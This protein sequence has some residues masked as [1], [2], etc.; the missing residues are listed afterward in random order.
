[1]LCCL[2]RVNHGGVCI[3]LWCTMQFCRSDD[4]YIY[5]FIYMGCIWAQEA[6]TL[7]THGKISQAKYIS[8]L[9]SKLDVYSILLKIDFVRFA[10]SE[11]WIIA[12]F[13]RRKEY[14]A[15]SIGYCNYWLEIVQDVQVPRC[16]LSPP[17][18][19]DMVMPRRLS[20]VFE[21]WHEAPGWRRFTLIIM[22]V[23]DRISLS[24]SVVVASVIIQQWNMTCLYS[25]CSKYA[26]TWFFVYEDMAERTSIKRVT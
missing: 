14:P 26:G 25:V 11:Q 6:K 13:I 21:R 10:Q 15:S 17:C 24:S 18:T 4:I 12:S 5:F 22:R 8:R 20:R 23:H 3:H 16:S 1:M 7:S 2:S 19:D 9:N